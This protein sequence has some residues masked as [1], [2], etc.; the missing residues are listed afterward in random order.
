MTDE[1]TPP[2]AESTDSP[3]DLEAAEAPRAEKIERARAILRLAV[4]VT[5]SLSLVA[6]ALLIVLG[7]LGLGT[8]DNAI[9][10][11]AEFVTW[12][13][14]FLGPVLFVVAMNLLVWRAL[15]RNLA[16]RSP[17]AAVA[18][19]IVTVIVLAVASVF[20]VA[21]LLLAGFFAGA[22]IGG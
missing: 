8:A 21:T 6:T 16:R 17:G 7:A 14:I 9:T 18:I 5:A 3:S 2:A 19:V 13:L 15:L 22:V 20:V 12:L 10:G 1:T 4:I 11:D